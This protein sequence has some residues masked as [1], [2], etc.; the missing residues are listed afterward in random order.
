VKSRNAA[1]SGP[2]AALQVSEDGMTIVY[3][4][5]GG[6]IALA[7]VRWAGVR[8]ASGEDAEDA[9]DAIHAAPSRG[10]A[11]VPVSGKLRAWWYD[12]R[13][14][15]AC[16][17]MASPGSADSCMADASGASETPATSVILE[18]AAPGPEG[19]GNDWLL[20]VEPEGEEAP[21]G[22]RL[23]SSS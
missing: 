19:P 1:I 20:V 2:G 3:A 16:V 12:P 18:Y 10:T 21:F 8:D 4:Y 15:E 6:R 22:E 14:G 9:E 11:D 7:P 23:R 5:S 17:A 13:N